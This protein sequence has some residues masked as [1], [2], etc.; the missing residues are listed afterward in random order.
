MIFFN[1]HTGHPA[2]L[3]DAAMRGFCDIFQNRDDCLG[4][5]LR[6]F[7][8]NSLREFLLNDLR[9][10]SVNFHINCVTEK[11]FHV[12]LLY[13]AHLN[14]KICYIAEIGSERGNL[15]IRQ[16]S[17]LEQVDRVIRHI[18]LKPGRDEKALF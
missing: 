12:N 3:F 2:D 5:N 13:P 18:R 9:K 17:D 1:T 16:E 8:R 11:L 14:K 4:F 15:L 10:S 7:L 6:E